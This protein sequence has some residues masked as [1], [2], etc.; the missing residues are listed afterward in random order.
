MKKIILFF[1]VA[2]LL[3]AC[4]GGGNKPAAS[5]KSV[6]EFDSI[7]DS[8]RLKVGENTVDVDVKVVYP[9]NNESIKKDLMELVKLKGQGDDFD[10]YADSVKVDTADMKS[11]VEYL[12]KSKAKWVQVNV[13]D[14]PGDVPAYYDFEL[15][16]MEETDGY[17]TMAVREEL[18]AGH[19]HPCTTC[20]GITYL[21]PDGK[22]IG[23]DDLNA[24][25]KDELA[26]ELEKKVKA[27]F[28]E[29]IKGDDI[30]IDDV[31]QL[32]AGEHID[33][34]EEGFYLIT[35][36]VFFAYQSDEIASYAFGMPD[37][38]MSL[39]EMKEKDLLGSTLSDLVK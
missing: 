20:Y 36:S 2:L 27:F 22:K 8:L 35:D 3:A 32:E 34:P 5:E 15:S 1:G 28:T 25:K 29:L 33:F 23:F 16:V 19:P 4:T 10:G 14:L 13:E 39:K 7:S 31:L 11:L 37:I 30:S 9:T 6:I 38:K 17:I 21:K 18:M 24:S 26:L 12:V